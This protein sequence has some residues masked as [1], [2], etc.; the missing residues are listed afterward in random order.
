MKRIFLTLSMAVMLMPGIDA[1]VLREAQQPAVSDNDSILKRKKDIRRFHFDP[2]NPD[3]HDPVMAFEDGKYYVFNTG[4]GIGVL[5][6]DDLKY[7]RREKGVFEQ[8]PEWAKSLIP[9]YRGHTW[10][11][12]ILK[13]G[14]TWHLYYSCSAFGKN[15]S[16]IG[17]ATNKTLDPESP[18]FKW[19][20]QGLVVRSIPGKTDWNAIDPNVI[21][22]RKG[23]P[24]LTFGS[25]WDGIQ[26]VRLKEDM[27]TTVGKPKTIARKRRPC[28]FSHNQPEAGSNAIEAPFIIEK[29][30]WYYLFASHDFCCKGLESNY[31]TVVGRSRN[32]DGPYLDKEGNEMLHGGG[33]LLIGP[34][35]DYAGVGHCSVYN[36]G[37]S[38]IF[39][40]HGYDKTKNGA[41]K[42]VLHE[43]IWDANGWPSV[44]Q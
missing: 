8:A 6:S 20:D 23:N 38:W 9:S 34:N 29:D 27:K 30:G 44:R 28:D 7:W 33:T 2:S 5:S 14:D 3:V 18:D 40:A 42:L 16:V 1:V 37:D 12:D 22:D 41:S 39:A 31:K 13:V 24:W 43:L 11:P 19:V 17:L 21:I 36:F 26:L 4:M 35:E 32:V 15:T 10:A 25:F